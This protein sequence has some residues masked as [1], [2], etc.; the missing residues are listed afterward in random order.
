V[1]VAAFAFQV[2]GVARVVEASA[3]MPLL[4]ALRDLLGLTGTKHGCG[5]GVCGACV[6]HM[7]G[8]P[9]RTC[10][11]TVAEA[12][13]HSI[14]TIEGLA[15]RLDH[16]LLQAWL[17]E[18]VPQCG[19]CMPGQI[20]AAAALLAVTPHPTDADIDAAMDSHTCRCGTYRRIR[21]AIHRAAGE[22]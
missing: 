1:V 9:V 20:M 14:T 5:V 10:L 19:Y 12:A 17:A 15:A 13:G 2:N 21:R 3:D 4:W 22:P 7:D 6:A 8:R 18:D 16:P 11:T